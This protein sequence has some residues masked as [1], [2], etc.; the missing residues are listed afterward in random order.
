MER[1]PFTAMHAA[2][3]WLKAL[4]R[5]RAS[6]SDFGHTMWPAELEFCEELGGCREACPNA[7]TL[8]DRFALR[9]L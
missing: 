4:P 7:S 3:N 2:S 6:V 1:W 8:G 5:G 9:T